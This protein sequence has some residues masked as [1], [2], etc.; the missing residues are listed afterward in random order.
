MPFLHWLTIEFN[1]TL[2][3][4]LK[5]WHENTRRTYGNDKRLRPRVGVAVTE[6]PFPMT[7]IYQR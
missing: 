6:I 1:I 3:F 5:E 4:L 2:F 7:D